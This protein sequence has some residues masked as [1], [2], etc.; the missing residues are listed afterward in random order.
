MIRELDYL[1]LS[2]LSYGFFKDEDIGFTLEDI[3]FL[4]ETSKKRLLSFPNEVWSYGGRDIF[5]KTFHKFLCQWKI[6]GIMDDTY[7]QGTEKTGFYAI[8]FEKYGE[9]VIAYRGTELGSFGEAYKDFIETDLLIGMDKKPKQFEQGVEFYREMLKLKPKNISLTGHSLGGG[10]AQYVTLISDM[11]NYG[12]PKVY[13]WNAI[14]IN[15]VG[16]LNIFDF[17]SFDSIIEKKYLQLKNNNTHYKKV[18][19]AYYNYLFKMFKK[20]G[21]IKDKENINNFSRDNFK[22]EIEEELEKKFEDLFVTTE[23]KHLI[24]FFYGKKDVEKIDKYQLIVDI[25]T[26]FKD[27]FNEERLFQELEFARKFL[28]IFRENKRY[29]ERVINFV[30]SEDFTISLYTHLGSTYAIDKGLVKLEENLHP[31]LKKVYAFTKSM[32]SF[33]MYQVFLPFFVFQGKNKGIISKDLNLD[34]IATVSRKIIYH[35]HDLSDDFLGFYYEKQ[36]LTEKNYYFCKKELLHGIS[37]CKSEIKYL[38]ETALAIKHMDYLKF[39]ILWKYI[40]NKIGSPYR[41]KDIY[42]LIIFH[43]REKG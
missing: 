7:R 29:N 16:I 9:I 2:G 41:K 34:Y 24:P 20:N 42:D 4:N 27:I 36:E 26:F 39:R 25:K 43:K 28:K 8:A 17:I 37:S 23:S 12:I 6:V 19:N 15:K 33:H 38:K 10:I 14:G 21:Y 13:T 35:E 1:V 18:K 31:L 32:K 30:H 40:T 5:E 3:L 11:Y 22:L